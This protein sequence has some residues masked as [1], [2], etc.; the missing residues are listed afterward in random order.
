MLNKNLLNT[1]DKV[2][3]EYP[4]SMVDDQKRDIPRMAFNIELS[5][6]SSQQKSPNE[7]AICDIGGGVGLFSVGC[8]AFGFKRTVL[9]DDFNDSINHQL[10]T[11]ILDLHRNHGVEVISRDVVAEGIRDIE[12]QFDVITSFDSVEHWHNSPKK[13]FAE[14]VEKLKPNG[15]F[16][17][18]VPNCVNL[19]KRI[20]FP[21]GIGKWS[22]MQEWY[23]AEVFRGHVREPDV[24]DLKYIAR[25]MNLADVKIYGRNWAAGYNS[26]KPAVRRVAKII[27]FPLRLRPSLCSHIYLVGRKSQSAQ[28]AL[29]DSSGPQ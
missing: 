8:A 27:D 18:A 23:E 4:K 24:G 2:A 3:H 5:V 21:L 29:A 25:D 28:S 17:L 1:L 16:V 14:V 11:S 13:V 26:S 12:G 19:R 10:G 20:T 15:I 6:E 7:M 9:V 22:S